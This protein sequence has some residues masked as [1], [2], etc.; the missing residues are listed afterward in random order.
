MGGRQTYRLGDLA[1]ERKVKTLKNHIKAARAEFNRDE[2]DKREKAGD[3]LEGQAI[4]YREDQRQ[5]AGYRQ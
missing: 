1:T 2:G 4:G 5:K 3:R